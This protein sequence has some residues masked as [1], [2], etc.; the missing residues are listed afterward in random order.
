VIVWLNGTHGSGKTTTAALLPELLDDARVFDAE[1]VG[2]MLM[3]VRPP[4]PET[5]DFQHWD[6]WR[7]LVVDT[8]RRLLD[9]TGGV[10]VIPMTVLIEPYWREIRDGLDGYGIPVRHFVLHA[11]PATLRRR[12]DQDPVMGPSTFRRAHVDPYEAAFRDWLSGD[13]EV[14]DTVANTPA[15]VAQAIAAAMNGEAGR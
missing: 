2:A 5:D 3:D 13:A 11:D 14:V 8:A 6:P 9:F 1:N 15:E 12:I 10:L 4:L 7:P